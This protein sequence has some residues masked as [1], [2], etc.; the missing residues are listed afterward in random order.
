[1]RTPGRLESY[2]PDGSTESKFISQ[3]RKGALFEGVGPI[4]QRESANPSE[5]GRNRKIVTTDAIKPS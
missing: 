1:L 4:Q 3:L 5:N 2:P